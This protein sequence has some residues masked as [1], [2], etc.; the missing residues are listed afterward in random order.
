MIEY[1]AAPLVSACTRPPTSMAASLA[2]QDVDPGSSPIAIDAILESRSFQFLEAE[3]VLQSRL[4]CREIAHMICRSDAMAA[5]FAVSRWHENGGSIQTWRAAWELCMA[6][7]A[8]SDQPPSIWQNAE[9]LLY[10]CA[11]TEFTSNYNRHL[12]ET[13]WGSPY[14]SLTDLSFEYINVALPSRV[15]R[16]RIVNGL[17]HHI[18]WV[19][20][21][22]DGL[23]PQLEVIGVLATF[24]ISNGPVHFYWSFMLLLVSVLDKSAVS[25]CC[26]QINGILGDR[27]RTRVTCYF[28]PSPATL[29]GW[30][31]DRSGR[32]LMSMSTDNPRPTLTDPMH[33]AFYR[34]IVCLL[35]DGLDDDPDTL[36]FVCVGRHRREARDGQDYTWDEFAEW[37]REFPATLHAWVSAPTSHLPP[38][39]AP[40]HLGSHHPSENL[41]WKYILFCAAAARRGTPH[42][43]H[44]LGALDD[45]PPT[46][47]SVPESLP[48][49]VSTASSASRSTSPSYRYMA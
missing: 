33:Q 24:F 18:R 21:Q 11:C 22:Q 29:P 45:G 13:L 2:H 1:P 40:P 14:Q 3:D 31:V 42:G 28:A 35:L 48:S 38:C 16:Q 47:R 15:S 19:R 43:N 6:A 49:L 46:P 44:W 39:S 26:I 5:S 20:R 7:A 9:T 36:C 34:N 25:V 10:T 37:Y 17:E 23:G 41:E 32:L 12:P 30:D 27:H 8:A 4:V